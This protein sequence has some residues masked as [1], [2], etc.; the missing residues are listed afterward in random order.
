MVGRESS[1]RTQVE[2]RA[3]EQTE[4]NSYCP[5]WFGIDRTIVYVLEDAW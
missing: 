2:C 3:L 1:S 4:E 5:L